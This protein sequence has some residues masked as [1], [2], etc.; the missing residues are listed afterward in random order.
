VRRSG[1]HHLPINTEAAPRCSQL[2]SVWERHDAIQASLCRWRKS[3]TP[4]R[5]RVCLC[6][7]MQ[8][9]PVAWNP[10]FLFCVPSSCFC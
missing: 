1:S 5:R 3:F 2:S 7:D 9:C 8:R 6:L 10:A 4:C